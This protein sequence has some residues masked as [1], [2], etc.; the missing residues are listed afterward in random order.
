MLKRLRHRRHRRRFSRLGGTVFNSIQRLGMLRCFQVVQGP[1]PH[2]REELTAGRDGTGFGVIYA[3]RTARLPE[4]RLGRSIW[5]AVLMAT[6]V[7][8][9]KRSRLDDAC[10]PVLYV[11]LMA[12]RGGSRQSPLRAPWLG[13]TSR[14]EL[15]AFETVVRK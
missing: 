1:D 5:S 12:S 14:R 13:E 4:L 7:K 11:S 6:G 2:Q 8:V 10:A 15:E 9:R 3:G